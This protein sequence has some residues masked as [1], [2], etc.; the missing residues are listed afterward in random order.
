MYVH[1]HRIFNHSPAAPHQTCGARPPWLLGPRRGYSVRAVAPPRA[2]ALCPAPAVKATFAG[3]AAFC[4]LACRC[5]A[6]AM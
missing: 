5:L 2:A 3:D 4:R 6:G 1:E